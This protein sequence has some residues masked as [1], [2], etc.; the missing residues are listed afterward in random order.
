MF[1]LWFTLLGGS[2]VFLDV[3]LAIVFLAFPF[4]W[5]LWFIYDWQV[6]SIVHRCRVIT[7]WFAKSFVFCVLFGYDYVVFQFVNCIWKFDCLV[8]N[9]TIDVFIFY[10]FKRGICNCNI[11][12]IVSP[13]RI[14]QIYLNI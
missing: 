7:M 12:I 10:F 6:S 2:F 5:V 4:F 3:G 13:W 1:P 8:L 14:L 11:V 9:V